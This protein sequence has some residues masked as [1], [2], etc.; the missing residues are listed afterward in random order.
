MG[1][2]GSIIKSYGNKSRRASTKS[3]SRYGY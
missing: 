1:V 3:G 2:L